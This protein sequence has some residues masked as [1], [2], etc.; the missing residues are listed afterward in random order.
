MPKKTIAVKMD[1]RVA[2]RVKR[3][4]A[5]RGIK[6]GFFVEKALLEQLEREEMTE[7]L[8]DFKKHRADEGL[9]MSFEEYLRMR[10]V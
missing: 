5:R 9:A 4:C 8:L 2:E 3:Y 10:H 6:Q 1:S 7:D